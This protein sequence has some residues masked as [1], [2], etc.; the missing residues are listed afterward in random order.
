MQFPITL[1][2]LVLSLGSNSQTEGPTPQSNQ[3][4]R[5]RPCKYNFKPH[6]KQHNL[7]Q[8]SD[9]PLWNPILL[10][11]G[12]STSSVTSA[13]LGKIPSHMCKFYNQMKLGNRS[14]TGVVRKG[15]YPGDSFPLIK[16]ATSAITTLS[17]ATTAATTQEGGPGPN[18]YQS[19]STPKKNRKYVLDKA[20]V[21]GAHTREL[22]TAKG[23]DIYIIYINI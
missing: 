11:K 5:E 23:N 20:M 13:L 1:Q 14:S 2:G 9:P 4:P 16:E 18:I 21:F 6:T 10:E 15:Q 22:Q 17:S 7:V 12:N 3:K 8:H 19:N